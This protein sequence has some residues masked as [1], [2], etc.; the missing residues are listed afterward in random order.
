MTSILEKIG[1]FQV[2]KNVFLGM[3][4]KKP[5]RK[6]ISKKKYCQLRVRYECFGPK[7]K[8]G[9]FVI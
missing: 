4:E 2:K 3:L 1:I 9:F 8:T 6:S 7:K 5:Q